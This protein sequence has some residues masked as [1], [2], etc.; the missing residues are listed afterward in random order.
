MGRFSNTV[1]RLDAHLDRGYALPVPRRWV[2]RQN[3]WRAA[4]HG[5]D[6]SLILD[7]TGTRRAMREAVEELLEELA[8]VAR[9]LGCADELASVRGILDTGSSYIR[10]RQVI[11]DGGGLT[12][13]VDALVDELAKGEPRRH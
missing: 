8:P 5:L 13:V 6:A 10:Q 11:K 4:R 2:V 9:R 12:D 1:V 7:D 3:K